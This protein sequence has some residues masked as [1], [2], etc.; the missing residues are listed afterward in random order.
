MHRKRK[1]SKK[2]PVLA[3]TE[4]R[5]KLEKLLKTCS[6]VENPR[7]DIKHLCRKQLDQELN[8]KMPYLYCKTKA[9]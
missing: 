8:K 3:I 4:N 6:K 7:A 5:S 9:P 2:K 1:N